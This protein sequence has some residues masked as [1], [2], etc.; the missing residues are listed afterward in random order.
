M[1]LSRISFTCRHR[2]P[3]MQSSTAI[4]QGH[5]LV[6]DG[7]HTALGGARGDDV[8]LASKDGLEVLLK[9]D[10]VGQRASAFEVNEDVDVRVGSGVA[11]CNR[12]EDSWMR[13]P[14]LLTRAHN[15]P[16]L[17]LYVGERRRPAGRCWH[18][19]VAGD[20]IRDHG[21]SRRGKP[22]PVYG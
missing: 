8:H 10:D 21:D 17:T 4:S 18:G 9:R 5:R 13:R 15:A 1:M 22:L 19:D 16:S 3:G 14:M 7:C 6:Q 12:A 11:A 20:P 2:I